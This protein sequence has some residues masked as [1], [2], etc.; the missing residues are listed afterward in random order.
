MTAELKLAEAEATPD[1]GPAPSGWPHLAKTAVV[2]GGIVLVLLFWWWCS[3]A[4][5]RAIRNLPSGE[6]QALLARTLDNLKSVCRAPED[7]MREF[8]E[9]Q[10]QL[11]LEIPECDGVC[12][13]LVREHLAR[14]RAPVK[15]SEGELVGE[16]SLERVL[17]EDGPAARR[18]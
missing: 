13:G 15:L 4:E 7:A 18:K 17:A 5:S 9:K 11:A 6:R 3:D 1:A 12:Q 16:V 2:A 14:A 10:A 8:C